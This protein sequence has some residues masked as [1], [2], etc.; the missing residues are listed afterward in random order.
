[1]MHILDQSETQSPVVNVVNAK[2]S[3]DNVQIFQNDTHR[4]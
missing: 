1:M 2:S 4:I 3:V